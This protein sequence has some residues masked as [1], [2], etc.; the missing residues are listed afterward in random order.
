VQS[1]VLYYCTHRGDYTLHPVYV[2]EDARAAIAE[3]LTTID[4]ALEK[5][6]LPAA[7]RRKACE[8]CDYRPV[9]G[10]YEEER[11]GRKDQASL[12]PLFHL[13]QIQ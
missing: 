1:S 8:F 9:C 7:P 11:T 4:L 3:V 6:F 10:P 2:G 12:E 13:R 5:G